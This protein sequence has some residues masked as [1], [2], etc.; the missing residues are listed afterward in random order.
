MGVTTYAETLERAIKTEGMEERIW[1]ENTARREARKGNSRSR[2]K[3]KAQENE[4]HEGNKKSKGAT[5]GSQNPNNEVENCLK[6]NCKHS[7]ECRA[8][9]R[10]YYK[11]GQDAHIKRNCP[12]MQAGNGG[13]Q[14][15]GNLV[16]ARVFALTQGKVKA[17]NTVV[18]SHI[19]IAGTPCRFLFDS[20]AMHSFISMKM[21]VRLGVTY[22]TFSENFVISLPL[23]EVMLS[24]KWLRSIPIM[25]EGKECLGDLLEL[26][27]I[28]YD[29]IIS[30]N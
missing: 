26:D 5:R 12:Q 19:S 24:T 6:C 15:N 28:D 14:K 20:G 11:C 27:M 4:S 8:N 13:H 16:P 21:V 3:R 9:T 30:I 2:D 29:V 10:A 23:G 1:K 7:G 17:N 18:T 22:E 25:I